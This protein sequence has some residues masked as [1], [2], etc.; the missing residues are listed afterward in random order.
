[1]TTT[2]PAGAA[3]RRLIVTITHGDEFDADGELAR[4]GWTEEV[5]AG[6]ATPEQCEASDVNG[7]G[8]I[9]VD[10]DDQYAVVVPGR[11]VGRT[12]TAYVTT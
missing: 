4:Q 10:L 2:D 9:S 5:D 8:F 1:V 12:A 11:R 6:P 3:T 7:Q